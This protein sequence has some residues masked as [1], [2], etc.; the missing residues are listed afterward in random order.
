M[1]PDS[2]L[3]TSVFGTKSPA[4][5]KNAFA[6]D[7]KFDDA[8]DAKVPIAIGARTR[9]EDST[10]SV[11]ERLQAALLEGVNDHG[12]NDTSDDAKVADGKEANADSGDA[13][14]AGFVAVPLHVQTRST[15]APLDDAPRQFA[16]RPPLQGNKSD[17]P[18]AAFGTAGRV[19]I[20]AKAALAAA[21]EANSHPV[22]VEPAETVLLPNRDDAEGGETPF[23]EPLL[24]EERAATVKAEDLN[25]HA[26]ALPKPSTQLS[27]PNTVQIQLFGSDTNHLQP[28]TIMEAIKAEPSWAAYFRD[29]GN[30]GGKPIQSLRIQLHPAELGAVTAHL[31]AAGDAIEVEIAAETAEAHKHLAAEADDILRSLRQIGIDVDRISIHLANN[32]ADARNPPSQE[33]RN[34]SS[35]QGQHRGENENPHLNRTAGE[36]AAD[37]G[38]IGPNSG[39]RANQ[40]TGRYI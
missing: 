2:K 16:T 12:E 32:S 37:G 26:N 7:M 31:R 18:Q 39:S 11:R 35:F 27:A 38:P 19:N 21:A 34:F 25:P 20:E 40:S 15:P 24:K 3:I 4:A 5:S 6:T 14:P 36:D 17:G 9:A 22:P 28:Q 29:T 13:E 33:W 1:T 23:A 30:S 10:K 8:L